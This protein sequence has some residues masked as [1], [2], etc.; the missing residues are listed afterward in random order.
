MNLGELML[1]CA[2]AGWFASPIPFAYTIAMGLAFHGFIVFWEE[3]RHLGLYG[4]KYEQYMKCVNRWVPNFQRGLSPLEV[5]T[6]FD[7]KGEQTEPIAS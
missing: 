1:F 3:P 6:E 2:L 7:Q 4:A 5:D